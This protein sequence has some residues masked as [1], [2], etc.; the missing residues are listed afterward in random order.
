MKKSIL[1]LLFIVISIYTL[2]SQDYIP[3]PSDYAKWN[4]LY[5][6]SNGT[7]E[8]VDNYSYIFEGDTTINNKNYKKVI[9]YP[10]N[11]NDYYF[12]GIREDSLKNIYFFPSY[13][14]QTPFHFQFPSDTEEHLLYTF[15]S[16]YVGKILPINSANTMIRVDGIDS[17]LIGDIYHKR[18]R[19]YNDRLLSDDY[20]IEGIGSDK[21]LFSP[22]VEEFEWQF[23]T[24][25]FTDTATYQI[26]DYTPGGGIFVGDSCYVELPV[27]IKEIETNSFSSY[28]NP[29]ENELVLNSNAKFKNAW[30]SFYNI[31]G[32]NIWTIKL[33]MKKQ[34]LM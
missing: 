3:F 32:Q 25:C 5:Y 13:N 26:T 6:G 9:A 15:D 1:P 23:Y 30:V 33:I 24:L 28:P 11:G 7:S 16:L 29:V 27:N 8:S 31:H 20:W 14:N 34:F 17:I 12:G 2:K 19:I 21:E 10:S 18:Y 4:T 22:Y